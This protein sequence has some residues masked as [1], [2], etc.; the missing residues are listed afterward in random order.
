MTMSRGTRAML[1]LAPLLA[2]GCASSDLKTLQ[3]SW[4]GQEKMTGTEC[5]MVLSGSQADFSLPKAGAWYKG[6]VTLDEKAAPKALDYKITEC[7][8]PQY[9]GKTAKGIYQIKDGT[10]TIAADE[11]GTEGRPASFESPAARVFVLQRDK[12]GK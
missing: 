1:V 8:A 4:T 10:V 12:E 5:T 2:A 11:P 9:A 7:S 3:G 6:T